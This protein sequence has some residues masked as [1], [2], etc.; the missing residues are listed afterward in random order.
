M[1]RFSS[2]TLACPNPGRLAAFYAEI[3]GGEVTFVHESEWASMGCEGTRIEFMGVADYD[4]PRW[5]QDTS[6][7]HIDFYVDDLA[8][9][10]RG[11]EQAG[12]LRFEHQHNAAPCLVFADPDGHPF[13][14]SLID[15]VH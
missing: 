13:G 3:T 5:P 1:V 6:L 4:P 9:A 15:E 8:E 2:I 7:V 10:A 14:L 11:V 12:A